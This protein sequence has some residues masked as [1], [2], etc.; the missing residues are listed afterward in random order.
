[1]SL[2]VT[3]LGDHSQLLCVS[4]KPPLSVVIHWSGTSVKWI[5]D[6]IPSLWAY[7]FSFTTERRGEGARN[8]GKDSEEESYTFIITVFS[9]LFF[10]PSFRSRFILS[11]SPLSLST[12]SLSISPSSCRQ[13]SI[14]ALQLFPHLLPPVLPRPPSVVFESGK[15][16]SRRAN[17]RW[18]YSN[19]PLCHLLR[20][21]DCA[22]NPL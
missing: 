6:H 13:L 15:A 5:L 4:L 7:D 17:S 9:A 18:T 10:S 2:G 14:P 1:M 8:R 3:A 16:G 20:S 12:F 19:T 11:S 22:A 21:H